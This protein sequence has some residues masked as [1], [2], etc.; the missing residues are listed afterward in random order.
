HWAS[1]RQSGAGR[2]ELSVAGGL[3][4]RPI[5]RQIIEG[6]Q[7][8]MCVARSG[9]LHFDGNVRQIAEVVEQAPVMASVA[10]LGGDDRE[11]RA[12]M[13]G[14]EAPQMQVFEAVAVALDDR[15]HPFR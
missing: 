4:T 13:A 11:D 5:R 14:T 10:R 12:K 3:V 2:R 9:L 15:A 1:A 8:G 6:H 7:R